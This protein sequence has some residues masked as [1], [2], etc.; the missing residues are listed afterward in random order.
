MEK[1]RILIVEDA[2]YMRETIEMMLDTERYEV[3]GTAVNGREAV[4]KYKELKP[5]LVTMDLVMEEMDGIRAT[6]EIKR[7]DP[8]ALILVISALGTSKYIDEA[9]EAGAGEYLWKPFT[10]EN[11]F[12][13]F[14]RLLGTDEE[15]KPGL[16]S[17]FLSSL[18]GSR[19]KVEIVTYLHG[20]YPNISDSADISKHTNI[21]QATVLRELQGMGSRSDKSN[22]LL[23]MGLVDKIEIGDETY[24]KLSGQGKWFLQNLFKVF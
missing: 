22:S 14:E 3:V 24:Y 13:V 21:D 16:E 17:K 10:V 5:D 8:H 7:Y 1:K 11:L 18:E 9:M 23:G 15:P 12:E 4:K 20:I 19:D 6:K 2:P